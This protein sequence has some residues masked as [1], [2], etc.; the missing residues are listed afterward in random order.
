LKID[1]SSE[2]EYRLRLSSEYLKRAEKFLGTGDYKESVE[3]SQLS[4]ENA[5]KAVIALRRIPSW[6]HDPSDELMEISRELSD[7][8]RSMVEELARIAH[9]LAPEH[10]IT[11]YGKP[12]EGL[13][14]WEVYDEEKAR[15]TLNKAKRA[16]ELT[17]TLLSQ[18][19]VHY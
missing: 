14:P 5:A 4:V 18:R 17:L 7:S 16:S 12:A 15:E 9:E 1:P 2:A 19:S 8:Q 3:A 10:G 11:T 6:A 13:I